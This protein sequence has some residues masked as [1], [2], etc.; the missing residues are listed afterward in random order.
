V[1]IRKVVGAQKNQLVY[2]FGFE[3]IA[4]AFISA[5][6]GVGIAVLF[7]PFFND[8][9]GKGIGIS[10]STGLQLLGVSAILGVVV[11]ALAGAYPAMYLS[12]FRPALVLKGGFTSRLQ[13]G[14][15]RPLVVLQFSL[16]A[17]L[18]IS[19]LIMYRQ[20]RF[21]ASHDLGFDKEAIV[22]LPTQADGPEGIK[23]VGHLR[24]RLLQENGIISVGG[25]DIS[26]NQGYSRSG[27][28][29]NGQQR[30]AYVYSVDEYYVPTLNLELVAGRNFDVNIPSD[31]EA[32]IVNEALVRDMKWENPVG[33][34][35]NWIEDTLSL[36][37]VVIGVVK[38][39]HYRSLESAIDPMML[40][41]EW[42]FGTALVKIEPGNIPETLERMGKVWKETFPDVPFNYSFLEDDLAKQ[43]TS[44]ERWIGIM[45]FSTGFAIIIS[46]LGLF[47]LAGINALNKTKEVGIRKVMG[48]GL[49]NIFILLN[50]QY[51]VL[52]LLAF[53]LAI[54]GSYYVM[55]RWLSDFKF[56]I[57]MGW[58]IFALSMLTGVL[59]AVLTVSYHGFK[60]AAI[61]PAETL[62]Y[63]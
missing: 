56:R 6:F 46:C 52:S 21:V 18:I 43:Y 8:F 20:M 38:D 33:E 29:I 12:R 22:V 57:E 60:A 36:G 40:H 26:F 28:K 58:E 17:F 23:R 7:L 16:S 5:L 3:S 24:T 62:K 13:A 45:G 27:Y 11:G 19:S 37:P 63:E 30:S 1:G 42:S 49:S 55:S 14:F 4:L 47:G 61:N 31:S 2:Q 39:Y 34:H 53:V 54:P 15:T 48:A 44:Y 10:G 41:R 51:I 32:V 59:V 25:T 50:R 9:T 35:Y